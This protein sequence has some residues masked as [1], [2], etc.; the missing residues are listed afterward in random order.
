[1]ETRYSRAKKDEALEAL[2]RPGENGDFLTWKERYNHG[3]H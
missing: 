2:N 1:M 3:K